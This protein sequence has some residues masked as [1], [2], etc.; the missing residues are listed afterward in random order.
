MWLVLV[1]HTYIYEYIYMKYIYICIYIWRDSV[2]GIDSYFCG[3]W[4]ARRAA[5]SKLETQESQL[6]KFQ[7]KG[8]EGYCPSLKVIT[9]RANS[10]LLSLFILLR[11][12]TDL[13][14]FTCIGEGICFTRSTNSN[15]SLIQKYPYRVPHGSVK[16][17]HKISHQYV[18]K[19]NLIYLEK[20]WYVIALTDVM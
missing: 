19:L 10:P 7:S 17:T 1:L 15:V 6:Y 12:S 13:L 4:K 9:Q 14:R 16:L 8:G 20:H 5:V 3:G 11:P 18:I 2:Q